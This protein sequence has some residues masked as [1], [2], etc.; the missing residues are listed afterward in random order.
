LIRQRCGYAE[1]WKTFEVIFCL[2]FTLLVL[3][4]LLY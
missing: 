1:Y 4:F 3:I 2:S